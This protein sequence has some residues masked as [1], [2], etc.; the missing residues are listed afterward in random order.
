[1]GTMKQQ[2]LSIAIGQWRKLPFKVRAHPFVRYWVSQA[3]RL[4]PGKIETPADVRTSVKTSAVILELSQPSLEPDVTEMEIAFSIVMPTF[5]RKHIIG[6][7]IVS[8]LAQ[9]LDNYELIIVDDGSD[10]GSD[11]F[12]KQTWGEH[13]ASGRFRY[14]GREKIGLCQ[15]RNTAIMAARNQWICYLDSDNEWQPD[16]LQCFAMAIRSFPEHRTFYGNIS[17]IDRGGKETGNPFSYRQLKER[18]FID[19]NAYCHDRDVIDECGYFDTMLTRLVD[20]DLVLRHTARYEPVY[21]PKVLVR[22]RDTDDSVTRT[23][24]GLVNQDRINAKAGNTDIHVVFKVPA[25]LHNKEEWGDYHLATSLARVQASRNY[26]VDIE[27]LEQWDRTPPRGRIS[28]NFVIRGISKYRPREGSINVLWLISHPDSITAEECNQYDL[29]LVASRRWLERHAAQLQVPCAEF[30]Q[31]TDT[32]VFYPDTR[33]DRGSEVLFV[34]NSRNIYR[35]AVRYAV[36]GGHPLSLYGS[37]WDQFVP[38]ELIKG[39]NIPNHELRNYYSSAQV[40]LNDHWESMKTDGFVSNRIYDVS[41]CK[42]SLLSDYMD[43]IPLLYGSTI[44]TFTDHA[45]FEE[46]IQELRAS[47]GTEENRDAAYR[48]TLQ[49]FSLVSRGRDLDRVLASL[50]NPVRHEYDADHAQYNKLVREKWDENTINVSIIAKAA[51]RMVCRIQDSTVLPRPITTGDF[52]TTQ[53]RIAVHFHVYYVDLLPEFTRILAGATFPFTL[54]IT[55]DDQGK[56]ELIRTHFGD[57][58]P[59]FRLE[60]VDNIGADL[61]PMLLALQESWRDFDLVCHVHT[62]KSPT[63]KFGDDWRRYLL[64]KLLGRDNAAAVIRRFDSEPDIGLLYPCNYP[65]IVN[66]DRWNGNHGLASAIVEKIGIYP[67]LGG[68]G[69]KLAFPAGNMYWFRPQALSQ[70]FTCS[71]GEERDAW[72]VA[73][74]A[75]NGT[76]GHTLERLVPKIADYNGYRCAAYRFDDRE[77]KPVPRRR[78]ALYICYSPDGPLPEV[79]FEQL[80]QLTELCADVHVAANSPIAIEDKERIKAITRGEILQREN[81]GLDTGAWKE[82]VLQLGRA[83]IESYDEILLMNDSCYSSGHSLASVFSDMEGESCDFWGLTAHEE[84]A[85]STA[86]Y[87]PLKSKGDL[88]PWHLQS[89]FLVYRALPISSGDFYRFWVSFEVPNNRNEAIFNGEVPLSCYFLDKGYEAGVAFPES[90]GMATTVATCINLPEM[91]AV[92]GIPLLKKKALNKGW[93]R[94]RLLEALAHR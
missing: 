19:L 6:R 79:V 68:P 83:A 91:Y 36:E 46:S 64:D 82:L 5:N 75:V 88:I 7:A 69:D 27:C 37:L 14:I 78:L 13:F 23:V 80:E 34:G 73:P 85:L 39:R 50:A 59:D 90:A 54:I 24:E 48:R 22:Y 18:N 20:Y 12:L 29:V 56:A 9:T 51:R 55:T 62:K 57:G 53:L 17:L 11:E 28:I 60:I 35:P 89:Y 3:S 8:V 16:V 76:I 42:G 45:A 49:S 58:I 81:T 33:P 25:R 4:R 72:V 26:D 15:A 40:V 31:F 71:L 10:D 70:L 67:F 74:G 30:H 94:D 52:P 63:V 38:E 21:I 93:R 84:A 32:T 92:L 61:R 87:A 66:D 41:A 2:I 65:F 1:M 47:G 43:E 44:N 77:L 86:Q